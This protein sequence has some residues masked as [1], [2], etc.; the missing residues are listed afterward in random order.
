MLYYVVTR[1][2]RRS[3]RIDR[4]DVVSSANSGRLTNFLKYFGRTG[5]YF[6]PEGSDK[7]VYSDASGQGGLVVSYI[8]ADKS[9]CDEVAK[10]INTAALAA[11]TERS[12]FKP[13][14]VKGE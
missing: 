8:G 4:A 13:T 6:R 3:G 12:N 14:M 2:N 5:G 10:G 9:Y 11:K 1:F 7:L